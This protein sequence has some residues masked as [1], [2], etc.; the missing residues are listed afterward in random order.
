[1]KGRIWWRME[2]LNGRKAERPH[3]KMVKTRGSRWLCQSIFRK[4]HTFNLATLKPGCLWLSSSTHSDS[5]SL[6]A[7]PRNSWGIIIKQKQ[8]QS[9]APTP[10][11]PAP[12]GWQG[13]QLQTQ[14]KLSPICLQKN[15]HLI[16]VLSS[17][18]V[19]SSAGNNHIFTKKQRLTS[20]FFHFRLEAT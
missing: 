14:H 18:A 4:P 17:L 10:Q 20:A 19:C 13:N 15:F 11:V 7:R 6:S 3:P 12:R 2:E 8:N 9:P 5:I 16:S 1:M